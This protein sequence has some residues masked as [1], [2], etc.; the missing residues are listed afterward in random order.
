[1]ILTNTTNTD[2]VKKVKRSRRKAGIPNPI[3]ETMDAVNNLSDVMI[4]SRLAGD[5]RSFLTSDKVMGFAVGVVVGNAFSDF[6]KTFVDLSSGIVQFIYVWLVKGI[7]NGAVIPW[8]NFIKSFFTMIL[9][10]ASVFAL[11]KLL[12]LML[13]RNPKERF[14]YNASLAETIEVRKEQQETN[15]LLRELIELNKSQQNDAKML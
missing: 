13:V 4:D 10:A 2:E 3:S 1:M 12:N 7:V 5:F 9:I 11:V 15:K 8:A 14:G 6:V